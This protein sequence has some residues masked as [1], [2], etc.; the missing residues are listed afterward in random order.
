MRRRRGAAEESLAELEEQRT[1][2]ASNVERQEATLAGAQRAVSEARELEAAAVLDDPDPAAARARRAEAE[3]VFVAATGD[4][5]VLR[6]AIE[7]LE[8]RIEASGGSSSALSMRARSGWVSAS[9]RTPSRRACLRRPAR[10]AA[11]VS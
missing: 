10:S 3:A 1:K 8:R 7:L 6:R 9:S 11:P 4:L 2:L 5:E